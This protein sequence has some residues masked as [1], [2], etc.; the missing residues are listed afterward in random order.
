MYQHCKLADPRARSAI[1]Q[2]AARIKS[3]IEHLSQS[4]TV[5]P[6]TSPSACQ[7]LVVALS[8]EQAM[9]HPTSVRLV[10]ANC[11]RRVHWPGFALLNVCL[12]ERYVVIELDGYQFLI[13]APKL[14]SRW[15]ER[16]P[17]VQTV[18][19]V[20]QPFHPSPGPDSNIA[21]SVGARRVIFRTG[22][23]KCSQFAIS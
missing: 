17:I 7:K 19:H 9:K 18:P 21:T 23:S 1:E 16:T 6:R 2:E 15:R 11:Q 4:H 12:K 3:Q 10:N 14:S 8:D 5:L 13:R 22:D 20:L